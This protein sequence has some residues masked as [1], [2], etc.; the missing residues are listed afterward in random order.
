MIEMT[1]KSDREERIKKAIGQ[2]MARNQG[3][4]QRRGKGQKGKP[5]HSIRYE[6]QRERA[7]TMQ[8]ETRKDV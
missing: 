5:F 8:R 7:V 1:D 2:F 4:R 3:K 6:P